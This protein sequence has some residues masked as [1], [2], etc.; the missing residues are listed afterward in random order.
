MIEIMHTII[1][2][3]RF[4]NGVHWELWQKAFAPNY[5]LLRRDHFGNKKVLF[6]H[7]IFHLESPGALIHPYV[8][9]PG[10]L[11]CSRTPLFI[12]FSRFVLQAY[13]LYDILPPTVPTI[14]FSQ[15]RRIPSKNIGRIL[16]N[17]KEVLGVLNEGNMVDIRAVDLAE[18]SFRDQLAAVRSSNIII[19]VHGAGLMNIM[20]AAEEAILLEIHPSYRLDRH[21]R[22][23]A[24]M[25]GKIYMPLRSQQRE[26][27]QGT[28]DNVVVSID[29][30]R[31]TVDAAV[32]IARNFDDGLAECGLV[33]PLGILA[34]DRSLDN[35]Y[36]RH[37][38][39]RS[40]PQST[41]FPC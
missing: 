40:A 26:T 39:V 18:L 15:R 37:K 17:E 24:R 22:H 1:G 31:K 13:D 12:A 27:C 16:V 8:A 2:C 11:R 30:F 34:L 4:P 6:K 23:A 5:P 10:P 25:T 20:F 28:S 32:R 38:M 21:F 14:L 7:L 33:C 35:E 29:E 36:S 9:D 3:Y 19:G 41:V